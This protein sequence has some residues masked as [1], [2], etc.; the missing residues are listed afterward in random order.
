MKQ[1]I[2]IVFLIF[3]ALVPVRVVGDT[4][5][6]ELFDGVEVAGF[7]LT[8]SARDA[9][10]TL[11]ARGFDTGNLNTYDDWQQSG[12]IAVKGDRNAPEG[13]A[14]IMLTRNGDQLIEIREHLIR[15]RN[16]FPVV[17]E[18]DAKRS[19]FGLPADARD[20]KTSPNGK[21]GACGVEDAD[22]TAVYSLTFNG[23]R[24]RYS[25][26]TRLDLQPAEG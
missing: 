24:Q 8:T 21:A 23:D 22:Q 10:E 11:K 14:E 7:T 18:I 6:R 19:H 12:L 20:C 26:V 16:P 4:A 5:A 9:F 15:L 3:V 2:Q 17:A 25:V 1:S 13:H